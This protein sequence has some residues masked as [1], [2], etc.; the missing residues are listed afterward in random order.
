MNFRHFF[1]CLACVIL[2]SCSGSMRSDDIKFRQYYLKGEQLYT[3][4]CSN[5][6]QKSGK[7]LGLLYPPLDSSDFMKTNADEVLCI[8]KNGSDGGLVINSETFNQP[9]PAFP[10]LT[11]L[12][13]AQI[14][15]YIYNTWSNEKGIF[16][17]KEVSLKLK[18]CTKH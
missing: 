16:E 13:I 8:I 17:V 12:E 6:H 15:T 11:D 18:G 7:G 1:I 14:A 3:S 10:S 5:C 4:N 2:I 9:M